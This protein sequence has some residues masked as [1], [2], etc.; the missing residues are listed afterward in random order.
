MTRKFDCYPTGSTSAPSHRVRDVVVS[1]FVMPTDFSTFPLVVV[2]CA[3]L[4]RRVVVPRRS[5]RNV[6]KIYSGIVGWFDA[7]VTIHEYNIER[8]GGGLRHGMD[9][10]V[11]RTAL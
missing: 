11:I 10:N 3:A 8:G 9:N 2:H 1:E 4:R 5:P 7:R 6:S